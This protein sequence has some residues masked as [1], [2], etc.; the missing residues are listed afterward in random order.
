MAER[1]EISVNEATGSYVI[2]DAAGDRS[3]VRNGG[4][5][6]LEEGKWQDGTG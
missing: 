4:K 3:R 5:S 2:Q 1:A 6:W